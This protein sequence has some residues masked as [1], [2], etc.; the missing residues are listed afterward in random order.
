MTPAPTVTVWAL[1]SMS[2]ESS[3]LRE[4]WLVV[5]SA[6]PLKEW[7]RPEGAELRAGG[8]EVLDFGGG[9]GLVEVLGVEGVVA[10]PGWCGGRRPAGLPVLLRRIGRAWFQ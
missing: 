9:F 10:G 1:S 3:C 2:M 8:D 4:I 6:M 5:L 7:P